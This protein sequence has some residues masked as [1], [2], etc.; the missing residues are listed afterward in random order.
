MMTKKVP[1]FSKESDIPEDW[2][3]YDSY[4]VLP[5]NKN[6]T[7][8]NVKKNELNKNKQ[9]KQNNNIKNNDKNIESEWCNLSEEAKPYLK[10]QTIEDMQKNQNN[11]VKKDINTNNTIRKMKAKQNKKQDINSV[12]YGKE[13][14]NGIN[15]DKSTTKEENNKN[16]NTTSK[17]QIQNEQMKQVDNENILRLKNNFKRQYSEISKELNK[18]S[19][20]LNEIG[21]PK[22]NKEQ[23]ILYN[24]DEKKI[25]TIVGKMSEIMQNVMKYFDFKLLEKQSFKSFFDFKEE[26]STNLVAVYSDLKEKIIETKDFNCLKDFVKKRE[27]FF[28]YLEKC[29]ISFKTNQKYAFSFS[30]NFVK[31]VKYLINKT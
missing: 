19:A 17:E 2:N 21:N 23:H 6:S 26:F 13:N 7:N 15:S 18:Y 29:G 16:Q 5:N 11:D 20:S 24:S 8:N 30:M 9:V 25:M 1:V 12:L 27:H 3:I 14:N 22:L 4:I 28:K 31:S 10:L